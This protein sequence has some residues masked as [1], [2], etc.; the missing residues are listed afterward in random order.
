MR[1]RQIATTLILI[2]FALLLISLGGCGDETSIA[3]DDLASG[4]IRFDLGVS[5]ASTQTFAHSAGRVHTQAVETPLDCSAEGI[6]QIRARVY[7]PEG[8]QIAE[9]G[10]WACELHE[11]LIE[12]VP[13][14][15]GRTVRILTYDSQEQ[16][17]KV[18]QTAGVEVIADETRDAGVV[19]LTPFI[20]TLIAPASDSEISIS[21][22]NL[23]W[24]AR[25]AS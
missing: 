10:P 6:S 18:G 24:Q 12:N 23:S 14:G 3:R 2:S 1:P 20:P 9:G 25:L 15:T 5:S 22:L 7:G 8:D 13:A 11:G 16:P 17:V 4:N 19:N 21:N